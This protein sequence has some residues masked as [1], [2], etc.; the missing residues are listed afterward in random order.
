MPARR[1]AAG[2]AAGGAGG[3]DARLKVTPAASPAP[4]AP[5]HL[6]PADDVGVLRQ[7]VH[8]LAFAL[9]APLGPQHD[10]HLVAGEGGGALAVGDGG[11]RGA[12]L[13]HGSRCPLRLRSRHMR[14]RAAA[15][16]LPPPPP[17][18]AVVPLPRPGAAAYRPRQLPRRSPARQTPA[19]RRS[20]APL[21]R[22]TPEPPPP[23]LPAAFFLPCPCAAPPRLAA[24][25]TLPSALRGL[26][27]AGR[28]AEPGAVH[29][30]ARSPRG[31][32]L[33]QAAS[34]SVSPCGPAAAR[35]RAGQG[36]AAAEWPHAQRARLR[37]GG[38]CALWRWKERA[39][40]AEGGGLWCL[41]SGIGSER[42]QA[43]AR[44]LVA[45]GPVPVAQG[46]PFGRPRP[47]VLQ[48]SPQGSWARAGASGPCQAG[49]P[50]AGAAPRLRSGCL[51]WGQGGAVAALA[52]VSP[53]S[54]GSACF[55]CVVGFA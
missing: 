12:M 8:H 30:G 26:P 50:G 20:P 52:G 41:G 44:G 18:R 11:R 21:P 32:H 28:R 54:V 38:G 55:A 23:P 45:A 17:G 13:R 39:G 14:Q 48:V 51:C 27:S 16:L 4:R 33:E 42:A 24:R 2:R 53:A 37:R 3:G 34:P 29:A 49:G 36:A 19:L 7:Q 35:G 15:P 10:G 47:D 40:G 22:G 25:T 9:V 31:P 1:R 6:A 46:R 5:P 43:A